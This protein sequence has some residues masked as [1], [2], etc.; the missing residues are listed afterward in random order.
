MLNLALL[1]F[2]ARSCDPRQPPYL[3][4]GAMGA[5]SGDSETQR[6]RDA[7]GGRERSTPAT[8]VSGTSSMGWWVRVPAVI[9]QQSSRRTEEMT[10]DTGRGGGEDNI[11]FYFFWGEITIFG[12]RNSPNRPVF[13]WEIPAGGPSTAIAPTLACGTV[14]N[15]ELSR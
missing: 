12:S 3:D 13:L 1:G 7:D 9:T 15:S 4:G 11:L 14:C 5:A 2:G 6:R 8:V 10:S